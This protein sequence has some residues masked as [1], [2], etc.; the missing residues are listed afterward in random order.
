MSEKIQDLCGPVEKA[1]GEYIEDGCG[2]KFAWCFPEV[3]VR[4]NAPHTCHCFYIMY[5]YVKKSKL[6]EN[7]KA[8]NLMNIDA[9]LV[10]SLCLYFV[11]FII[12]CPHSRKLKFINYLSYKLCL[13]HPLSMN[14]DDVSKNQH[15]KLCTSV[16]TRDSWVCEV[17]NAL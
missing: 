15:G 13:C 3:H 4:M 14:D 11:T 6:K 1:R 16:Q 8:H 10:C 9:R 12:V 7:N 17:F 2:P 5:F